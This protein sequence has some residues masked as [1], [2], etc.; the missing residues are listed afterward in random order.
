MTKICDLFA[1]PCLVS[2]SDDFWLIAEVQSSWEDGLV[3]MGLTQ[4]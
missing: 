2:P 4:G 3:N 1:F